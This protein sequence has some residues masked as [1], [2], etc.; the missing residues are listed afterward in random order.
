MER[1]TKRSHSYWD[2]WLRTAKQRL[3]AFTVCLM[4]A[5]GIIAGGESHSHVESNTPTPTTISVISNSASGTMTF[6]S[7]SL[8]HLS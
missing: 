1:K 6:S 2:I 8:R 7:G 4:L 5:L 3:A